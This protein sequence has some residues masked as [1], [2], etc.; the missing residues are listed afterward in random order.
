MMDLENENT[1]E[2]ETLRLQEFAY[3][4]HKLSVKR[5]TGIFILVDAFLLVLVV[6]EL[7]KYI[8]NF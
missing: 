3:Q 7:I 5:L 8:Q 2:K 6:L 4:K 1:T